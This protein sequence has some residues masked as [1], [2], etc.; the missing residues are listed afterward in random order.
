M[1][2]KSDLY[3]DILDF[4]YDEYKVT[5]GRVV[6][7]IDDI[8]LGNEGRE[9]ELAMLFV[10]IRE[11][12][13]IVDGFRRLT[14]VKMYKSFLLGVS[15][16]ATAN[17][18]YLRSFNGD[19]VLVVFDG[20]A[21]RTHAVK[22]ALQIKW[23]C[24]ELLKPEVDD[25]MESNS[26]LKDMEFDFGI[27]IDVGKVL[28]VRAGI[29]GENNNDLVWVGS[30]TNYAVKLSNLGESPYNIH[31]TEDVYKTMNEAVAKLDDGGNNMW[32]KTSLS[33][34]TVIYKTGHHWIIK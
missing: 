1:V 9:M 13:K 10:D 33:D 19:G 12:T 23:F 14:A 25:Y 3:S 6:P 16:I 24:K 21:K 26:K 17:D 28:I 2:S 34:G 15:K 7:D 30:A 22:T 11:S 5:D 8:G 31:I 18:G 20:T 29:R 27:G 32:T 4:F